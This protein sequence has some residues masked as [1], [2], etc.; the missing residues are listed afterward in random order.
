MRPRPINIHQP[1]PVIILAEGENLE[2]RLQELNLDEVAYLGTTPKKG[3]RD[4][5][6]S[7]LAHY[8]DEEYIKMSNNPSEELI[9]LEHIPSNKKNAS[10]E[11]DPV[12]HGDIFVPEVRELKNYALDESPWQLPEELLKYEGSDYLLSG[13]LFIYLFFICLDIACALFFTF[14]FLVGYF[15]AFFCLCC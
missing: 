14:F 13:Y 11:S 4:G 8:S 12:G 5:A 3:R 2:D 1:L 9:D 6:T 10:K 7:S 15:P